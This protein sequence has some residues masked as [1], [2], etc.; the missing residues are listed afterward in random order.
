MLVN[1]L[2]TI[3]LSSQIFLPISAGQILGAETEN[4]ATP[5]KIIN[6]NL[7]ISISAESA[8]V[9]DLESGKVLYQKNQNLQ[10]PIASITKLMTALVFL[11]L[12]TEENKIIKYSYLDNT[13]GEVVELKNG[14]EVKIKDLF[15]ASLVGS[16]NNTIKSLVR[17]T[18]L[19]ENEF[20]I[21]MNKKATELNLK[22]TSFKDTTGLS[23]FNVSTA[24]D[25]VILLKSASAKQAIQEALSKQEYIFQTSLAE[26]TV[27]TTNLLLNN[28]YFNIEFGKT[29]Y[30][31]EAGWCFTSLGK[32]QNNK[33]ITVVLGSNSPDMR[34]QDTKALYWWIQENFKFSNF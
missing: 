13:G 4:T 27:E 24:E 6:N 2:I 20:V 5:K 11:D 34:F 19:S 16:K 22:N 26:Y 31:E 32:I 14:E 33:I 8:I 1:L 15:Y 29:G 23:K 10:R 7:D 25:I 12:D 9:V 28:K 3:L 21:L 30:I 18:G 17:S